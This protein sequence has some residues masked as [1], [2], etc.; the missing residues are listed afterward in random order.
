M[1]T[2]NIYITTTIKGP[3]KRQ[4]GYGY[5]IEF[6]KKDGSSVTRSGV[7]YEEVTTENR[8]VLIALKSAL[9]RLIKSCSI[10]VFTKCGH[11]LSSYKNGWIL[12]WEKNSWT[13]AKGVKLSNWELWESIS[14]LSTNHI[15]KFAEGSVDNPYEMWI[16]GYIRKAEKEAKRDEK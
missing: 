6:I 2:V 16:S 11:I 5:V 9:K 14:E 12:E 15:I 8:L 1:D 7:G 4:G 3:S 10:L 13:N